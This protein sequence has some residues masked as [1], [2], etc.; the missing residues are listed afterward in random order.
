MNGTTLQMINPIPRKYVEEAYSLIVRFKERLPSRTD[1]G[2]DY[3]SDENAARRA[4][5]RY[6]QR[7]PSCGYSEYA[8]I[9][10]RLRLACGHL[11]NLKNDLEELLK[12]EPVCGTEGLRE[13]MDEMM[14]SYSE[15]IVGSLMEQIG[16]E[17][18]KQPLPPI[19]QIV[20]DILMMEREYKRI[21]AS[22]EQSFDLSELA[23]A[24]Q[25]SDLTIRSLYHL[26]MYGH[27]QSDRPLLGGADEAAF[28]AYIP[29]MI[30]ARSETREELKEAL[31]KSIKWVTIVNM[32]KINMEKH[33]EHQQTG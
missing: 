18:L 9:I 21:L 5:H 4:R 29:G 26:D 30:I 13:R 10:E 8:E 2:D 6:H 33:G 27:M 7:Y 15:T 3:F 16:K 1:L 20:E 31:P 19:V 14:G 23:T 11:D 24:S 32:G 28:A 25:I 17:P 22:G 12:I